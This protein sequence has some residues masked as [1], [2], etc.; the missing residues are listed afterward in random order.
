MPSLITPMVAHHSICPTEI[1]RL[2][3][4]DVQAHTTTVVVLPKGS[5]IQDTATPIAFQHV[6]I[7]NARKERFW[8]KEDGILSPIVK[9]KT[10]VP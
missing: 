9:C 4:Y 10:T 7:S 8:L 1:G 3:K 5:A 6:P 2:E